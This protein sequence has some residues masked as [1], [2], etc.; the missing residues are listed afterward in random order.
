V[1]EFERIDRLIAPLASGHPGTYGLAN[2][3]AVFACSAGNELVLTKDMMAEGVHFLPDDP[4]D[5]VARKLLRTNL[6]DLAAMGAAARGY[7]LGLAL[8]ANRDDTWIASFFSGLAQDQEIFGI[9]LL[10]GDTI[11]SERGVLTLSLTAIG[12][13]AA[14][15]ALTRSGAQAGDIVAVSGTIGDSA[16]GLMV[17]QEKLAA[18]GPQSA[19]FLGDRYRL[20]QPRLA[21][22]AALIG[23]ARAALDVS[24]GLLADAGHIARRSGLRVELDWPQVPLSAAAREAVDAR[25][26]LRGNIVAGGDDYELLFTL[27]EAHWPDI[28]RLAL[29]CDTPV[30]RIGRCVAGEGVALLDAGGAELATFMRGWRHGSRE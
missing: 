25:P 2:D 14:G 3:G 26:D 28:E 17:L 13:V 16:L 4:P 7:L 9:T 11:L 10:G 21:L 18:L 24:D 23:L 19:A 20:P 22:G 8:D 15:R 30:T 1:D 12:E 29:V 27:P 5:L 6:S